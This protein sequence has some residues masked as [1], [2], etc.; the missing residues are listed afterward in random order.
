MQLRDHSF[1]DPRDNLAYDDAL[2]HLADREGFGEIL[3]FW[4]SPVYFIVLGRI[5]SR[6]DDV[7]LGAA[8]ADGIK[9]LR[10]SSGGGT[11]I[12][13]PGCLNYSLILSKQNHPEIGRA[14]V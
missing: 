8:K 12:Q 2:L 4:E 11:V 3:R 1:A 5:G 10:R 14:H 13:G 6:E 7:D 9:V